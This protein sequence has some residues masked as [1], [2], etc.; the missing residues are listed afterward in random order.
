MSETEKTPRLSPKEKAAANPK[1]AKLAIA[2]H[3]YHD[4]QGETATNS[5]GTKL[6]IKNCPDKG[7]VLWPHRG[8]QTVTGGNVG[9]R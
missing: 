2:A 1:S 5:H 6:L 9:K 8:W 3:C 7:C 4:C